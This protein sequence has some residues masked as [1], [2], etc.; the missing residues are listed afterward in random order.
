MVAPVARIDEGHQTMVKSVHESRQSEVF[1]VG[2]SLPK[3][4]TKLRLWVVK[5][6]G[7]K[8]AGVH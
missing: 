4:W 2:T 6:N 7:G 5:A 1:E 8:D 3:E